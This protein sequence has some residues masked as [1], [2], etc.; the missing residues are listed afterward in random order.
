[1]TVSF[2]FARCGCAADFQSI[3][4][5]VFDDALLPSSLEAF[6][7]DERHHIAI[8][9]DG[10]TVI[11]FVSAVDYVHPDKPREIWINEVS[12]SGAWRGKGIAKQLLTMMLVHARDIGCAEAWVL[13]EPDNDAA[14]GLYRSISSD[15]DPEPSTAILHSFKLV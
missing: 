9:K 1:V 4:D 12:V 15:L 14:N 11:G 3:D 10:G 6:L 8:A 5:D 7:R 2:S 13:T